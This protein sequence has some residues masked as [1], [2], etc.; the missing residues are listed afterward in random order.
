VAILKSM[1]GSNFGFSLAWLWFVAVYAHVASLLVE[2]V[3]GGVCGSSVSLA[4]PH[5]LRGRV[6]AWTA[7]CD[8][9]GDVVT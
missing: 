3:A 2:T 7:W 8:L 4:V 6:T 9:I 1:F 5:F